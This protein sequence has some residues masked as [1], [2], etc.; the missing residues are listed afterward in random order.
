MK[1]PSHRPERDIFKDLE[2]LCASAGYIH[3]IAFFCFKDN[4][5]IISEE[6]GISSPYQENPLERLIRTEI[7]TLIGLMVKK[8]IDL[9]IPDPDLFVTYVNKTQELLNE[10]HRSMLPVEN[11]LD[12]NNVIQNPFTMGAFLR[13]GIFYSGESAYPL[14]YLELATK[15]YSQDNPWFKSNKGFVIEDVKDVAK[16]IMDLQTDKLMMVLCEQ[17]GEHID[18]RVFLNAFTFTLNDLQ[19]KIDIESNIIS[20]ILEAFSFLHTNEGFNAFGDFNT[21]N[22]FP[23]IKLNGSEFLLFQN[24]T[25]FEAMYETPYFWLNQDSSYSQI[26]SKNRGEYVESFTYERLKLVFGQNRVFKNVLIKDGKKI[27]NEI[28]VLVMFADRAIVLQAKSKKLTLASRKGNDLCLRDDFKKAIEDAYRQ[29]L[30]C[31]NS[32]IQNNYKMY[33]E[34]GKLLTLPT[35]IRTF[36]IFCVIS[37]NYPALSYQSEQFLKYE[38]TDKIMA[39][40]IMDVFF[41][42]ILTEF[43]STPLYFLSYVDRRTTYS[44]KVTTSNELLILYHHLKANLWID[45]DTT[46]VT[47]ADHE[48]FEL[49]EALLVRRENYQGKDT[50]DGILTRFKGT[51][52]DKIIKQIEFKEHP[53]AVNLGL[54]LLYCGEHFVKK[55]NQSLNKL[56]QLNKRDG[57]IHDIS[58]LLGKDQGLTL[59]FGEA[60]SET[61]RETLYAHCK[62]RKYIEKSQS[63]FGLILNN[64][65]SIQ[66]AT[67]LNYKWEKNS[68]LDKLTKSMLPIQDSLKKPKKRKIGRNDPCPC[69]SQK[70]YKKC[71]LNR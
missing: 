8:D 67:Q 1:T 37:E 7:A 4:S 28:D 30:N 70:K 17:N 40:F 11:F 27:I 52:F 41:L 22:A 31:C 2:S 50:P 33:S 29:G 59:Y 53:V 23:I 42:D 71:C 66:Y 13:E 45:D 48:C 46:R 14:Q 34:N 21:T 57:K 15:K 64:D 63:W 55:F 16:A 44:Q 39:P 65:F 18:G 58:L 51:H 6:G 12:S 69:G 35:K 19:Q 10:F 68:A 25:L 54:Y 9:S 60:Y 3:V 47:Y 24:Y 32:L 49:Y 56:I 38:T 36:H 26:A 61:L 20:K 43:L 5:L 62:K